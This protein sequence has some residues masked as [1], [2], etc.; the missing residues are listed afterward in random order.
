MKHLLHPVKLGPSTFDS[1]SG[2]SKNVGAIAASG[3]F[4]QTEAHF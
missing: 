3:V 2:Q 4:V 1:S